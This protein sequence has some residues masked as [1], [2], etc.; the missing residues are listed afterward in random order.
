MTQNHANEIALSHTIRGTTSSYV[1]HMHCPSDD[2][3]FEKHN[4]EM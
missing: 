4:I 1:A 3:W 2:R